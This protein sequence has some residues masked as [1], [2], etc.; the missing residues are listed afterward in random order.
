[1]SCYTGPAGTA[2]TGICAG[3]IQHCDEN[4]YPV[5]GCEGEVL[6]ELENCASQLDDDC[7]GAANE[8]GEFCACHPGDVVPCYTGAAETLGVGACHGGTQ[9]CRVDGLGYG[10]CAGEHVPAAEA[11]DAAMADE[12]CDGQ[13][14][15][16]GAGCVCGDGFLSPGEGEVCDDGNTL[17]GDACPSFCRSAHHAD[18]GRW[19]TDMRT[20]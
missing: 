12:D 4:G 11:C 18:R 2:G 5:G 7:D 9:E 6:P 14:N 15:E 17:D 1:M 10:V 13:S 3:G 16:E 8:E 19:D 20:P